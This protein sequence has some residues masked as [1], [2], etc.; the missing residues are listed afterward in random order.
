MYHAKYSSYY[1]NAK[2]QPTMPES[3]WR[4]CLSHTLGTNRINNPYGFLTQDWYSWDNGWTDASYE[5]TQL[6]E[7]WEQAPTLVK[8]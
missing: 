2:P 7:G 1:A 6:A 4:G 8:V 5:D 3:Y